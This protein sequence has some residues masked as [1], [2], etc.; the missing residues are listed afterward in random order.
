MAA[1]SSSASL[2]EYLKR[3]QSGAEDPKKSKKKKKKEKEKRNPQSA[4]GGVLVFDEDPVWQKPVQLEDVEEEDDSA[5]DETPQIDE[6]IEVK[7]L[8]RLE[9]LRSRKPYHAISEDGSGWV[10][11]P[12]PSSSTTDGPGMSPLRRDSGI[13]DLSPPRQQRRQRLDSLSPVMDKKPGS[14]PTMDLSPPRQRCRRLDSPSPEPQTKE[15]GVEASDLS[16]PRRGR[17][18]DLSPPRR[19]RKGATDTSLTHRS[20]SSPAPDFSPP[21]RNRKGSPDDSSPVL[22]TRR[23]P[24]ADLSPARRIIKGPAS[25][26]LSPPRRSAK[27]L[28]EP[29]ELHKGGR[30]INCPSTDL[31]LPRK[32]SSL[33]KEA[34]RGGLLSAKDMREEIDKKKKEEKS[35]F[36]AMDPSL[37]G[38]GAEAVY[39]DKEG[40]KISKEELMK[41]QEKPKEEKPL[42]WGKG[43]A[44]KREAEARAKELEIEMERPFARSRDDPELDKLLKERIRWGDPMAHL[45]KPKTSDPILED[46]GENE[47]MKESGFIIPQTIPNHSWLKRGLDFTPNRYGIRPGRHWDG[48]DR[49]N[50]YEKELFK[51]QNE[52]RATETEAYLWSVSDM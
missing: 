52:K 8:K 46:F 4:A 7:R 30:T 26:D 2:K 18:E 19:I 39:R 47:K 5:G 17:V 35:R 14:L 11:I 48:V 3:Y 44:Q 49:S 45:V 50:G 33:S 10:S 32:E 42:E 22:R 1:A 13:A 27:H 29:P 20:A 34:I 43:M 24:G 9:A 51:R 28:P 40:K 23:S 25:I 31:S 37:T 41:S 6:D 12:N 16:P 36:V 21:R 38:K 15:S